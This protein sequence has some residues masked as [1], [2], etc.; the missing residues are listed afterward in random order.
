MTSPTNN[1]APRVKGAPGLAPKGLKCLTSF[2]PNRQENC[3]SCKENVV[4]PQISD[5][6]Y[7]RRAFS[8]KGLNQVNGRVCGLTVTASIVMICDSL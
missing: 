8:M 7:V 1:I 5:R 2:S 3:F 4:F 6:F